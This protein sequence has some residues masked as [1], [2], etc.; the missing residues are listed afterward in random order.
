M[1]RLRAYRFHSLT[2]L[3]E[4]KGHSDK[5]A[6]NWRHSTLHTQQRVRIFQAC[7]VS[8]LFFCLNTM[9][10]KKADLRK[11]DGVHAKCLR[12]IFRSPFP[13]ISHISGATVLQRRHCKRL[14]AISKFRQPCLFQSIAVLPDDDV[15]S[16][17][18]IPASWRRT[19]FTM[20]AKHRKAALVT[21]FRPIASVR[22][23]Y[24][25]FAYM[26]LSVLDD[27]WKN[28]C[29]PQICSLTKLWRQTFRCGY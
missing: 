25:I 3:G 17:G 26:I 24:K 18:H 6:R 19:L 11:I 7:V 1:G 9:W 27:V 15:L 23:F 5:L 12:S 16:H 8:R 10:L 20:L 14:S 2:H 21:D 29:S 4:A 22:L 28:I 13:Y